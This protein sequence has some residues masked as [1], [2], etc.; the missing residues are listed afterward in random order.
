MGAKSEQLGSSVASLALLL[1]LTRLAHRQN[2][3]WQY[4][5]PESLS[6]WRLNKISYS[7]LIQSQILSIQQPSL[8]AYHNILAVYPAGHQLQGKT[9]IRCGNSRHLSPALL[10]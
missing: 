4:L 3:E 9:V 2:G 5:P 10:N 1:Q 8:R 6:K 7:T